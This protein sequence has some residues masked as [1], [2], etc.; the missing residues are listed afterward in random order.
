M[1][2]GLSYRAN[3]GAPLPMEEVNRTRGWADST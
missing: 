2:L 3:E 1:R